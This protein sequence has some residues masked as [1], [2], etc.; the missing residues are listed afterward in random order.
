[1][2]KTIRLKT[3][4]KP[5]YKYN[6]NQQI[7]LLPFKKNLIDQLITHLAKHDVTRNEFYADRSIPFG[8]DKSIPHDRLYI[9][10]TVFDCTVDDL[11]NHEVKATSFRE[12]L[13]E[14]KIKTT[15]K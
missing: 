10:A 8:S 14:K 1:M 5:S 7:G 2:A 13:G 4:T 11:V 15:L 12:T 3:R 9:Y 6:I